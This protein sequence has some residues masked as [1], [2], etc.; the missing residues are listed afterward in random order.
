M[1]GERERRLRVYRGWEGEAGN[2]GCGRD[3]LE[4]S[5]VEVVFE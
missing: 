2:D 1:R 5:V 3:D 4:I